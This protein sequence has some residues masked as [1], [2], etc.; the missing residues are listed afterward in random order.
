MSPRTGRPIAGTE[1]RT[2]QL[3]IRLTPSEKQ[4][5]TDISALSGMS[6]TQCIVSGLELLKRKLESSEN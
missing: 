5:L 6:R 1:G 3:V 4:M 2:E